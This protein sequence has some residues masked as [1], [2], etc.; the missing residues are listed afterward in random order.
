L[1]FYLAGQTSFGNRGCEALVRGTVD[2]LRECFGD[3]A[4]FLVP[5]VDAAADAAQ[6]PGHQ[7]IGV[8]FVAAP[9]LPRSLRTWVSVVNR[10]GFLRGLEP[11]VPRYGAEV[12]AALRRA[13]AVLMIGGDIVSLDYGVH[14][15]YFWSRLI[16]RARQIG[17]PTFLWAASVGPFEAEPRVVA[18]MRR[19]L[20]GY[21]GISVRES[22]SAEYLCQHYGVNAEVVGDPA[23]R[24]AV[25]EPRAFLG[26]DPQ[27]LAGSVGVNLKP[28]RPRPR[29]LPG[30]SMR[31]S[32]TSSNGWRPTAANASRCC[33]TS[34]RPRRRA[35]ATA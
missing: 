13:D 31:K 21:S 10:I 28:S 4:R 33:T 7:D 16:D 34:I 30:G 26:V 11:P 8:E 5:S 25:T 15:L 19:H 17:K 27:R 18:A 3:S 32:S 35:T 29:A 20:L 12:E 14:S 6:W 23:F 2:I 9:T 1:I 22:T 24:L